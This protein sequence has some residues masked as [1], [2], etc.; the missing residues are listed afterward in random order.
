MAGRF[1][2]ESN[3]IFNKN[4]FNAHKAKIFVGINIL[5]YIIVSI[6]AIHRWHLTVRTVKIAVANGRIY[7]NQ[8]PFF[9][10]APSSKNCILL[11]HHYF[12]MLSREIFFR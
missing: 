5:V 4:V 9:L 8:F 3:S 10:F 6:I 11:L 2:R 12:Y 7:Q 1:H